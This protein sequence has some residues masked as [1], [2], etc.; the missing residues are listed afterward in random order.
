MLLCLLCCL[1]SFA[2]NVIGLLCLFVLLLFDACWCL[3]AY[4]WCFVCVVVFIVFV[5]CL[6]VY[7]VCCFVF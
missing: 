1:F 6:F 4:L 5:G 3:F 2:L 7:L